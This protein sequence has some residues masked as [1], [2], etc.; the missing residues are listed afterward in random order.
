MRTLCEHIKDFDKVSHLI[1]QSTESSYEKKNVEIPAIKY[2]L[3][4]PMIERKHL[5]IWHI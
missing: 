2:F 3:M 5:S 1:N 4:H